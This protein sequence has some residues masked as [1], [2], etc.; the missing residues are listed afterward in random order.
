MYRYRCNPQVFTVGLDTNGLGGINFQMPERA[1]FKLGSLYVPA[2]VYPSKVCNSIRERLL[3]HNEQVKPAVP[4]ESARR[5]VHSPSRKLTVS[6]KKPR[7]VHDLSLSVVERQS[8]DLVRVIHCN[9]KCCQPE[10]QAA[11]EC[12]PSGVFDATNNFSANSGLALIHEISVPHGV[13]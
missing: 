7:H 5:E 6:H 13:V 2:G 3:F 1:Q 11:A 9:P 12:F 4:G 10:S 8:D